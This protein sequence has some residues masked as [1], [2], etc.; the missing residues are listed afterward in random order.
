MKPVRLQD[1]RHGSR[2]GGFVL[3]T[4]LVMLAVLTIIAVYAMTLVG[5]QRHI[6]ANAASIQAASAAAETGAATASAN[7]LQYQFAVAPLP[8]GSDGNWQT[9]I[10]GPAAWPKAPTS[11]SVAAVSIERLPA[12]TRPGESAVSGSYPGSR[13]PVYRVTATAA[14]PQSLGVQSTI[15][16]LVH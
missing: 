1:R 12:V 2:S 10:C 3:L 4:A 8:C 6:A 13:A 11:A 5:T 16:E 9:A 7:A 14:D 15:Q